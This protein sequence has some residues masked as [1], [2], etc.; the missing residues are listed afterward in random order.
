MTFSREA[1]TFYVK[2]LQQG[3]ATAERIDV[4]NIIRKFDYEDTEKAAD[5]LT[6][7]VD[8]FMLDNFDAPIFRKGAT[9]EVSWGYFGNMTPTRTTVIQEVKGFQVLTVVALAKSILMNKVHKVRRF[10]R[11]TRSQAV[12]TI[13]AENGY[14]PEVQHIQ[15]SEVVL[16]AIQQ[17]RETD[18]QFVMRLA[19]RE[20]WQFYVDF[21]GFHFHE[22]AL[23]QRPLK[24]YV[25]YLDQ[26]GE[27]LTLSVDN[28]VTAK[29]AQVQVK[30]RD[31]LAKQDFTVTAN[32]A[33][34]PRTGLAPVLE[35]VD[36]VTGK[37]SLQQGTGQSTVAP[38]SDTN[39]ATAT[40]A[41][42]GTFKNGQ[43]TAVQLSMTA[44]GDPSQLAKSIVQVS[45]IRSLSGK[46]YV[47]TVKHSLDASGKYVMD[48]K[49]RSDGRS[50]LLPKG[51]ASTAAQNTKA[52]SNDPAKLTPREVVDPVTGLTK[53]VYVDARGREG[54]A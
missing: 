15:D 24:E 44:M 37:T 7:E 27:I 26:H 1:P 45:G 48:L 49:M 41:A 38:T 14:G 51:A 9:L 34:V 20:G 2:A 53:I 28:D 29:P 46:Y 21:D 32:D 33:T 19:K 47:S 3:H 13:A 31:L 30:G 23:G 25:F 54:G 22:R 8:N 6:L 50:Q 35:I 11:M 52:T 39:Q 4:T 16:D 18:A 40:R 12:S 36:P 42:Q 10:D 43:L 17:A 5:K